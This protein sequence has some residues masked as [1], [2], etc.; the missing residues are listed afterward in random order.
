MSCVTTDDFLVRVT[1]FN[2][3]VLEIRTFH[4][5]DYFSGKKKES[6]NQKR[7]PKIS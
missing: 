6:L 3:T 1:K 5:T 7:D 2:S 4:L